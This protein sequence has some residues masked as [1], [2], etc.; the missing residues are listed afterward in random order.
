M[1]NLI[2]A[3]VVLALAAVGYACKNDDENPT[4]G[5]NTVQVTAT[6]SSQPISTSGTSTSSTATGNFMG[7]LDQTSDVLS[8]TVTYTGLTPTA[9]SLDPLTSM[10]DSTDYSHSILLA[11]NY[12][13]IITNPGSGTTT[14]PGSGTTTSPG[15]GSSTSPGSGSA[16]VIT[17]P[18]SGTT[19]L[20]ESRADSLQRGLYQLK[21]RSAAYPYGE[22]GG[23]VRVQ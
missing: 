17:T 23:V 8:Y 16:V 10:S 6:L 5:S 19:T 18:W 12:T 4:T 20:T 9:I 7:R 3:V 15:S 1:K 2:L 21:L 14:S 13:G 22:I 11:G